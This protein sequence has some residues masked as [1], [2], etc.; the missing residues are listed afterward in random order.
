MCADA[1]IL[2]PS[3][4]RRS[5]TLDQFDDKGG[6]S[7]REHDT[8]VSALH[9]HSTC[10]G[11]ARRL[12]VETSPIRDRQRAR[13]WIKGRHTA[14][15]CDAIGSQRAAPLDTTGRANRTANLKFKICVGRHTGDNRVEA[16][17]SGSRPQHQERTSIRRQATPA[18]SA[19]SRGGSKKG[20]KKRSAFP[21]THCTTISK[22]RSIGHLWDCLGT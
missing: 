19:I 1:S 20:I 22:A 14:D 6:Q 15:F 17:A 12:I 21:S 13:A 2:K 3:V 16:S 8:H 5:A 11:S 7:R 9:S 4:A 18:Q 10:L